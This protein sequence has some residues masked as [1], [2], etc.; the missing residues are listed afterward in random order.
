MMKD[1]DLDKTTYLLNSIMEAELAGVVRYTHYALMV[2]GP[3]RIPI[4]QFLKAQA[5]ESLLHAQQVGE[6]LTGLEGHPSL[7]IAT[8][9]ETD[10]HSVYDILLESLNH[11]TNALNLYKQ[12]LDVVEDASIYLEEFTRGMIGQEEL[13]GMELKKMLRDFH[14]NLA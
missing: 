9:E 1:L 11:E 2:T 7:R 5:S 6:I 8:I 4:V 3:N 14:P 10:K 13:H 12:L